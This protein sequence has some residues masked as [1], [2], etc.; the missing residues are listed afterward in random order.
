M[1]YMSLLVIGTA[2]E[3]LD[4]VLD[5]FLKNPKDK[6]YA[7]FTSL[8]EE[9]REMYETGRVQRHDAPEGKLVSVRERYG[10]DIDAFV[11][12][13]YPYAEKNEGG[14]YGQY[15][16]PN[17]K[18]SYF[19]VGGRNNGF[20]QLCPGGVGTLTER[21]SRYD[22]IPDRNTADITLFKYWDREL[23]SKI[24]AERAV[25]RHRYFFSQL[26]G[27]RLPVSD[28]DWKHFFKEDSPLHGYDLEGLYT[29][30]EAEYAAEAAGRANVSFA[31]FKDGVIYERQFEGRAG[32]PG[33]VEEF[34]TWTRTF[35]GLFDGLAPDTPLIA[36]TAYE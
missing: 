10:N 14:L 32:S 31:V 9:I 28:A 19:V 8:D 36:L 33:E 18:Y 25:E 20:F 21:H 11:T 30:T 6:R 34:H 17:G 4:A 27:I 35:C 15:E 24:Q 23:Q 7:N 22:P 13:H 3:Q 5:P 26:G 29:Q 12:A 2:P 1:T 16:N